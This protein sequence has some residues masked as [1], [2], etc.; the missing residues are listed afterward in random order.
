MRL[1]AQSYPTLT[2]GSQV[3]S[4]LP[5]GHIM[6]LIHKVKDKTQQ[7]WYIAHMLEEG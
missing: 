3:V 1:F 2:I 6:T 5:W 7:E 4:Q